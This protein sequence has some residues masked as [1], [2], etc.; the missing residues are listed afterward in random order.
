MLIVVAAG[1][2]GINLQHIGNGFS[3]YCDAPHVICVSS[4]GPRVAS[5][6][7][8]SAEDSPAFYTN[9]GKNSVDVAAPGGNGDAAHDFPFSQWPWTNPAHFTG[10]DRASL[11]WGFCAKQKLVIVRAA[12][13]V[14]GN[15]GFFGCQAGN[16]I[17]PYFGTSQASPHVAGL[18]ALL[19]AEK[20][21]GNPEQI[22]S[23]IQ[24]S[25]DV[26]DPALGRSRI[27]VR[28]AVG[29]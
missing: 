2:S 8:T 14:H 20:G 24:K 12:D 26:I 3:T 22:K 17:F 7:G 21:K 15:L 13:G 23:L 6:I 27:N 11:V 4:V 25:G 19:I 16:S 10:N 1:N 28:T 29:L 5:E 9:F 18:A